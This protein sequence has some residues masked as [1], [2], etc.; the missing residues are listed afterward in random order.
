M[1]IQLFYIQTYFFVSVVLQMIFL[2]ST[3]MATLVQILKLESKRKD[4]I[5]TQA[6]NLSMDTHLY[7]R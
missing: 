1:T 5:I 2:L 4:I 7:F 3:G 6:V